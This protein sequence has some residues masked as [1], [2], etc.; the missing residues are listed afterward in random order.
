MKP[1]EKCD[2]YSFGVVTL[3]IIM[4]HHPGKLIC[5]LSASSSSSSLSSSSTTICSSQ[6]DARNMLLKDLLDKGVPSPDPEMADEIVRIAKL[7][8][9]C[10]DSDPKNRP[11]M[12]QVYQ[13]LSTR[14][15]TLSEP[16]LQSITLGELVNFDMKVESRIKDS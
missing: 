16:L 2:V 8:L 4:G 15:F 3:E 5:L 11:T 10:I 9:N 6:F 7:A 13:D 14:R 12:Q 1:T